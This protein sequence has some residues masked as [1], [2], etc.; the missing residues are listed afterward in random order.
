[1]SVARRT[2]ALRVHCSAT[3][4]S[5]RPGHRASL[6]SAMACMNWNPGTGGDAFALAAAS[7]FVYLGGDLFCCNQSPLARVSATGTGAVD[8]PWSPAADGAVRALALDGV[9]S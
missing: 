8:A 6:R 4:A 7:D 9:S 5:M 3:A 2:C 1:M